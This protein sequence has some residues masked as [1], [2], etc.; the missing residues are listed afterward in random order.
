MRDNTRRNRNIGTSRQGRGQNNKMKV[1]SPFYS[2]DWRVFYERLTNY[3]S[4]RQTINRHEFLFLVEELKKGFQH[5]CTVDDVCE[6]IKH[7]P[8]EDYGLLD[9]VVFRQP[10]KKEVLLSPAWG[11]FVYSFRLQNDYFYAIILEAF[12]ETDEI[13][14]S[15]KLSV[16]K[17]KELLRLKKDGHPFV[18]EKR[19]YK[20]PMQLEYVRN[21][22]LYRTIPHEFGHYVHYYNNVTKHDTEEE[23][24]EE[25]ER[26][27]NAHVN[28]P[29]AVKEAFAE[30]YADRLQARLLKEKIIPFP[31]KE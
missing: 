4:Y 7:I 2:S 26:R 12:D 3:K 18:E 8:K 24:F 17:Q 30:S 31:R 20:A 27:Y 5:A 14:W 13:K 23:E 16:E 22:Q 9:L 21:T 15:K 28:L 29:K 6:I 11:R 10:K 19:Y 25:W 1:P